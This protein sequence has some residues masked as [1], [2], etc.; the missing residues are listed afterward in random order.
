[1]ALSQTD[2]EYVRGLVL[3]RSAIGLENEKLYLA[4]TRL[5]ALARREGIDS[6]ETL[7]RQLRTAPANGL[8]QKVVEAMTTNETSFFRDVQPFEMLKQVVVPE[9][10]KRRATERQLTIWC[11]ASSTGQEPYS[12][13][14]M[15]R[16]SFPAL[17][18]WKVRITTSDL[19]TEV[20]QKARK[21]CYSQLEVNRG[22]PAQ[23]LVKYFQ[24]QGVAWQIKDD[25][26]NLI[27]YRQLNLIEPWPALPPVGCHHD[28]QRADLFRRGNEAADPRQ[29][30]APAEAGRLPVHGRCGDDAQPGRFV[31]ARRVPK[32]GMLPVAEEIGAPAVAGDGEQRR[33]VPT[34]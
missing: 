12:L 9:L 3:R 4:E 14:M 5:Q 27:D 7:V 15:L 17:A 8:Q 33:G 6:L 18:S 20:L 13:A 16:E 11:A 32:G 34:S 19:S 30:A 28:P 24:R 22:L 21:G 31:R 23:M 1:V 10:M 26:R 25:I 2:F 29:G